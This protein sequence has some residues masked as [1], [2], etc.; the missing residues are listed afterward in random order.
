MKDLGL[1]R[2]GSGGNYYSNGRQ[3]GVEI[4]DVDAEKFMCSQEIIDYSAD[5]KGV[6]E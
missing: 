1:G 5:K 4:L 3:Y 2:F 6:Y